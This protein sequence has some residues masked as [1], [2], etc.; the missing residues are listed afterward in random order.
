MHTFSIVLGLL[1]MNIAFH[2]LVGALWVD[3]IQKIDNACFLTVMFRY[4]VLRDRI[5]YMSYSIPLPQPERRHGPG[6]FSGFSDFLLVLFL[7]PI[8]WGTTAAA[9]PPLPVCSPQAVPPRL[10]ISLLELC[11]C[12]LLVWI[13]NNVV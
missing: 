4:A 5:S 7:L 13:E 9:G 2:S 11:H 1:S 12:D 6:R 10:V 3:D 8:L